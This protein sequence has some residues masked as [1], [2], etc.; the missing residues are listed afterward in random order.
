[1]SYK[2]EEVINQT[3]DTIPVIHCNNCG[4]NFSYFGICYGKDENDNNVI[5]RTDYLV[6]GVGQKGYCPFCGKI[7]D[8]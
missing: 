2:K 6:M 8:Y 7:I 4:Q 1:M 5:N 3:I